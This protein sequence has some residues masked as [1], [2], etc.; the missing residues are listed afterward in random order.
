MMR[1]L[2]VPIALSL[3]S[4][5]ALAAMYDQARVVSA[6]P[7][8]GAAGHN[9]QRICEPVAANGAAPAGGTSATGVIVGGIAGGILGNQVGKGNGKT[10]ATAIG[11]VAGALAGNAVAN[12][13]G[14]APAQQRCYMGN[15]ESNRIVAYM[16]TYEYAGKTSTIRMGRDPG[17]TV[18]VSIT[19][20]D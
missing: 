2:L 5:Q 13:T 14:P 16:V 15:P 10:A 8:Y 11:A 1:R 20:I 17:P 7:V 3:L 4:S 19:V 12:N 18:R 9:M 6:T